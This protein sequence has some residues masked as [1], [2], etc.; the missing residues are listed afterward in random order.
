MRNSLLC[1]VYRKWLQ[2]HPEQ[3]RIKRQ[4]LKAEALQL[5]RKGQISRARKLYTQA[6]EIAHSILLSLRAP[7]NQSALYH[8]DLVSYAATAMAVNHCSEDQT[9]LRQYVLTDTQ[10]Q[11]NALMPMY[12]SE[13]SLLFTIQQLKEWLGYAEVLPT[14]AHLH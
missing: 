1:P 6:W 13:P 2:L 14:S 4:T 9:E 8:Q 3:A 7:E 10:H 11:L 5:R 12:A